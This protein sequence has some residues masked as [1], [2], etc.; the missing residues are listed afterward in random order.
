MLEQSDQSLLGALWTAKAS[1]LHADCCVSMQV[2]VRLQWAH[3]VNFAVAQLSK[4][5][6]RHEKACL[7]KSATG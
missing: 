3:F 2:D 1:K 5:E 4:F 6:P 7:R